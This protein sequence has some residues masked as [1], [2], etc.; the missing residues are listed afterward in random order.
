MPTKTSGMQS[1][2]KVFEL[3]RGGRIPEAFLRR[4]IA[5]VKETMAARFQEK[6]AVDKQYARYWSQIYKTPKSDPSPRV[7]HAIDGLLGMHKKLARKKLVAPSVLG[8]IGGVL[9]GRFGATITP[10]FDYAFTIPFLNY[11]NPSLTGSAN[12]NTGQISGSAVSDF[13]AASF[14]TMY[15]EMGIYLHPMF[16]PATLSVSAHPA[17][18]IEWWTNSLYADSTVVSLGQGALGIYGQQGEIGP[19]TGSIAPFDSWDEE[20]TQ[21]VLFDFG[22]NP[23]IPIS[24]ETQVDPSFNYA[25]FVSTV[26]HVQN[27]GWPGSLAGS[28]MSVTLP[29]ITFEL[30]LIQVANAG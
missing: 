14:G 5:Q 29:S 2:R 24:V 19:I 30:D 17:F 4:R 10:P 13:Q 6:E 26:N 1:Q 25:L 27:V 23:H 16:G 8:D 18:S 3:L 11:G 12:K 28:M 20:M 21:Q 7:M 22:S 15:T 9:P